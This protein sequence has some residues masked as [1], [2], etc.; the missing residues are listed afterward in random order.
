LIEDVSHDDTY[1]S[2]KVMIGL[3]KV[4][5][6]V[7]LISYYLLILDPVILKKVFAPAKHVKKVRCPSLWRIYMLE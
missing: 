6:S 4:N 5:G 2:L 3:I 1:S 7:S